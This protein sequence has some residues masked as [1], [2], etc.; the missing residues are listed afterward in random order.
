MIVRKPISWK[1]IR[2]HP[3]LALGCCQSEDKDDKD[4]SR[5]KALASSLLRMLFIGKLI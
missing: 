2:H 1:M 4:L 3:C 5:W